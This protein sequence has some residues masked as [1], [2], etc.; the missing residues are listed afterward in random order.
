MVN[1]L[2]Q[3]LD[4][5]FDFLD[6]LEKVTVRWFY[7]FNTSYYEI[8]ISLLVFKMLESQVNSLRNQ[9]KSTNQPTILL[10]FEMSMLF[11]IPLAQLIKKNELHNRA[12]IKKS[13]SHFCIFRQAQ[14]SDIES[15]EEDRKEIRFTAE[16]F[17]KWN[18]P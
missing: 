7:D 6:Y 3:A 13:Y 12:F 2:I 4:I 5:A 16:W 1:H 11:K 14:N 10:N 15:V 8:H 17:S 9:S 18:F